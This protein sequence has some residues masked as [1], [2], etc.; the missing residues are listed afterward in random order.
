MSN[1]ADNELGAIWQ[2]VSLFSLGQHVS[3]EMEPK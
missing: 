1:D 3:A 2:D